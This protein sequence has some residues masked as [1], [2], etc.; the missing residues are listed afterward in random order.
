MIVKPDEKGEI[1]ES[2]FERILTAGST[3]GEEREREKK[4]ELHDRR[5]DNGIK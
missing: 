5:N 2:R 3:R 1:G 4:K